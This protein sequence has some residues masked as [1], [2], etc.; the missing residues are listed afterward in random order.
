MPPLVYQ[1]SIKD[2]DIYTGT[3]KFNLPVV[4]TEIG[5]ID[6]IQIPGAETIRKILDCDS[7]NGS[8]MPFGIRVG[9]G[10]KRQRLDLGQT[11]KSGLHGEGVDGDQLIAD[12]AEILQLGEDIIGDLGIQQH[13]DADLLG[14]EGGRCN[15][16]Q[17]RQY[18]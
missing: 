1:T 5:N 6:D 11:I 4:E 3:V 14:G 10:D 2:S 7:I 13:V 17:Q 15:G 9:S 12:L 8:T 18:N 16:Q